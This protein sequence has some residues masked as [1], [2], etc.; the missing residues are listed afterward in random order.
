MTERFVAHQ[1]TVPVTFRIE[2][3]HWTQ[4][5]SSSSSRLCREYDK[6]PHGARISLDFAAMAT[7]ASTMPVLVS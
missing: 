4:E 1:A 6:A 2:V 3:S 5:H 7:W